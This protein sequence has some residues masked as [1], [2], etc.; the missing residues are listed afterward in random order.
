M[1]ARFYL[2]NVYLGM[3]SLGIECYSVSWE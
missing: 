3:E 2:V 1:S